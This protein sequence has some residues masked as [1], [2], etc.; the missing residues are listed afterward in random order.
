MMPAWQR[1][2]SAFQHNWL[3]NV[4][5]KGLHAFVAEI[6]CEC[7]SLPFI[8]E[9]LQKDFFAWEAKRA[10]ARWLVDAFEEEMSPGRLL[11]GYP[12][13]TTGAETRA[14][15]GDVVDALW[16]NRQPIEEM[17]QET[18]HALRTVD[19][20]YDALARRLAVTGA[21]A[22][23]P[24]EAMLPDFVVFEDACKRLARSLGSMPAEWKVV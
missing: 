4:Y 1:R 22:M 10:E 11:D 13:N 24:L 21:P 14:W 18:D 12:L 9:Y 19:R 5:L 20:L 15:L 8:D 7:P 3:K 2:R 23:A 6:S 17:R 16:K